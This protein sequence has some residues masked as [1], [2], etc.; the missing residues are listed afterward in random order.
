[1]LC[2]FSAEYR[3]HIG[4][5]TNSKIL[6]HCHNEIT[7]KA[8][9]KDCTMPI[10]LTKEQLMQQ[11]EF[12]NRNDSVSSSARHRINKIVQMLD[13]VSFDKRSDDIAITSEDELGELEKVLNN[14]LQKMHNNFESKKKQEN[15]LE[16]EMARMFESLEKETNARKKA[17]EKIVKF[18]MELE[19]ANY[20]REASRQA[21]E[22]YSSQIKQVNHELEQFAYLASH[23]LRAPLRAIDNLS[24]WIE[25]DLDEYLTV[26]T[27]TNMD[28]LRNRVHRMQKMIDDILKY[29]RAGRLGIELAN[30]DTGKLIDDVI[31]LLNPPPDF[32]ITSGKNMPRFK[33]QATPFKQI[34][35]NL[36]GNAIKHHDSD[37]G[38]VEV[39]VTD[40]GTHYKF[41]IK[42]DGPGIPQQYHEKIFGMFQTLKP[43]DE[44]EGSGMGLALVKK[45][46]DKM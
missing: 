22:N 37:N 20:N 31:D 29:S 40:A 4:M 16:L 7:V 32:S 1:M 44:V 25:E 41:R 23:D 26:E 6:V 33:T 3:D 10:I 34:F 19:H 9:R 5:P 12:K 39:S 42:D 18:S 28:L 21:L 43:R 35:I 2:A 45:I 8:S 15:S 30:I 27:R 14:L 11:I 13:S 24:L 17:E 36:I 38:K 46:L